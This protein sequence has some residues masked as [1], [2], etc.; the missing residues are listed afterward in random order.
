VALL[1][2]LGR[3]SVFPAGDSG[4][5]RGLRELFGQREDADLAASG[6]LDRMGDWR[7]Y[8]YFMLLGSRLLASE[9][10]AQ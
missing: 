9:A 1:R 5:T 2:G 4:G 7:G 8:V 10:E 3:L 6:L